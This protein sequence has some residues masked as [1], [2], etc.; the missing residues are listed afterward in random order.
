M[1]KTTEA[2]TASK[3]QASDYFGC[4][5]DFLC[6]QINEASLRPVRAGRYDMKE[7]A[8]LLM[9]DEPRNLTVSGRTQLAR[10]LMIERKEKEQRRDLV[11]WSEVE[12]TIG[13]VVTSCR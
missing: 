4:D 12:R 2:L 7:L 1:A 5:Y 3:R 6:Q 8:R 13:R 9:D 11:P 10:M